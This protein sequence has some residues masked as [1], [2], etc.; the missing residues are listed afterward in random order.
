MGVPKRAGRA[1]T[2]RPRWEIGGRWAE[3][4]ASGFRVREHK[5]SA[6]ILACYAHVAARRAVARSESDMIRRLQS[7][8]RCDRSLS[9]RRADRSLAGLG[10]TV[11]RVWSPRQV[12]L[13]VY[14][15]AGRFRRHLRGTPR[16]ETAD[17][18]ALLTRARAA[19]V[20]SSGQR[21]LCWLAPVSAPR[22]DR[23]FCMCTAGETHAITTTCC[24]Q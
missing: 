3:R 24:N 18:I 8:P 23:S 19:R 10:A 2:H 20:K 11:L 12:S 7:E 6:G 9:G 15:D 16:E 22:C 5:I 1:G 21:H 13:Q 14:Q 4:A 17:R